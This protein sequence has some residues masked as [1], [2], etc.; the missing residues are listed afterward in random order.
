MNSNCAA[1]CIGSFPDTDSEK[2]CKE[3]LM[4]FYEVPLWPQLPKRSFFEGMYLQYSEGFP[5]LSIDE[6]KKR[7]FMGNDETFENELEEFY[8]NVIEENISSF[9]ISEKFAKGLYDFIKLKDEIKRKNPLWIKGQITGPVSFGLTVTDENRK[10][11]FYNSNMKEALLMGL[12]MKAFWLVNELKKLHPRV[13]IS[14]D[15]PYLAS[16]GSG[17]ISMKPE[18]ILTDLTEIVKAI[19]GKEALVSLHCCGNTDWSVILKTG[20]DILSFDAYNFGE[21]I[22]LFENDVRNFFRNGGYIAWGIVPTNEEIYDLTV[23]ALFKRI[24]SLM[25][26][27]EKKG[28]NIKEILKK[29]FITPSCGMG[30]LSV[31]DS[32]KIQNLT[33]SLSDKIRSEI[34]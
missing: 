25:S 2:L 20:I 34:L 31:E 22:L 27:F 17:V 14:I 19:K 13:I 30:T 4:R 1:T 12:K 15:E 16:I 26:G 3:L 6:E 8:K 21:N 10:P 9:N 23:E 32:E 33:V 11:I 18:E 28:F 24:M 5:F 29:S 7:I